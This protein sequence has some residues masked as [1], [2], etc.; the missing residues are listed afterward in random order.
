MQKS[1]LLEK[2]SSWGCR[3]CGETSIQEKKNTQH[4]ICLVSFSTHTLNLSWQMKSSLC[5]KGALQNIAV[6]HVMQQKVQL[7]C[8]VSGKEVEGSILFLEAQRWLQW[9]RPDGRVY[10]PGRWTQTDKTAKGLS[11]WNVYGSQVKCLYAQVCLKPCNFLFCW[12]I[13]NDRICLKKSGQI[14]F[15]CACSVCDSLVSKKALCFVSIRQKKKK[16][17]MPFILDQ[18]LLGHCTSMKKHILK[19]L[20]NH[21]EIKAIVSS[22]WQVI[23]PH[24]QHLCVWWRTGT[25]SDSRW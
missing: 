4:P 20:K 23:S 2:S 22:I 13:I 11:W 25:A 1:T 21:K 6:S 24:W 3:T 15:F 19:H 18:Y 9:Q 10:I 16:K 7:P 8:S 5:R 14:G 12:N 17:I